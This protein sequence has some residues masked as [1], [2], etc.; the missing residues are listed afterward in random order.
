MGVRHET[1]RLALSR[2]PRSDD[3]FLWPSP[4]ESGGELTPDQQ[5]ISGI[6][7]LKV[8]RSAIP[9]V[10]HVD[11]SARIQTV[12]VETNPRYHKLVSAFK[13]LTGCPVVVNTSFNVRDEPIVCTPEDAFNCFMGT[14]I[15][16][17]ACGNA[18]LRKE[19]QVVSRRDAHRDRFLPD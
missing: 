19:R 17:L 1:G 6:D 3:T 18:I 12:D 14:G 11:Y 8:K 16:W 9:A 13:A 15:E 2:R 7:K 10:T 4:K 5:A